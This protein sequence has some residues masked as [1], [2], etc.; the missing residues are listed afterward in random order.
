MN[1]I[2]QQLEPLDDK[3]HGKKNERTDDNINNAFLVSS[4]EFQDSNQPVDDKDS[5]YQSEDNHFHFKYLAFF[6]N[7]IVS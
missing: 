3:R 7:I 1:F 6:C 5:N 4:G 2:V